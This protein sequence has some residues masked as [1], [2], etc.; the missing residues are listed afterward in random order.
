MNL[1]TLITTVLLIMGTSYGEEEDK[2]KSLDPNAT[3]LPRNGF[4]FEEHTTFPEQTD[5]NH[6]KFE[7][8]A[9]LP[10]KFEETPYSDQRENSG[11]VTFQDDN[12]IEDTGHKKRKRRRRRKPRYQ[13]P[14]QYPVAPGQGF[15]PG[16]PGQPLPGQALYATPG[17]GYPDGG[18]GFGPGGDRP[19]GQ[20]YSKFHFFYRCY[21]CFKPIY[22]VSTFYFDV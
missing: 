10:F 21:R 12:K 17:Q 7:D 14:G 9:D 11:P 19:A 20:F 4:R 15:Y 6:I 2:S 22:L 3:I 16:Y 5:I 18:P 8:E 13:N 1:I